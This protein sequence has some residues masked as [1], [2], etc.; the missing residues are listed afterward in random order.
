MQSFACDVT[1]LATFFTELRSSDES[2]LAPLK[3]RRTQWV[4]D[5]FPPGEVFCRGG[6]SVCGGLARF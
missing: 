1:E 5:D 2:S 3:W 4:V 6:R